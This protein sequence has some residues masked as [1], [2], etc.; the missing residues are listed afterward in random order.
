MSVSE[1]VTTTRRLAAVLAAD[2]VGYSRLMGADEEGTLARLKAHRRWLVDPKIREHRGR[3]VKTTGDGMLVEFASVV[4]AV[5]CAVEVQ[6]AMLDRE[7]DLTEDRRIQFRIGVNLGDIIVDGDDIFGDGVNVA[8]RLEALAEPGGIC[9][10]RTVRNQV[11]DKLPYG[12]EDMGEQSVKN[13]ARPVRAD[14]MSA[15]AVAATPLVAV[16]AQPV[17]ARRNIIPQRAVIAASLIVA[18]AVGLAAWWMWPHPGPSPAIVQAPAAPQSPPTAANPAP[19]VSIVV[20]PFANL[21]NDPEQEYF[22]DG[23]TDNLTTDLSRIV[24]SFVIARTTAFT[25]KGKSVDVKQIGKELGVRYVLEGSVRRLGGEVEVNAQLIDAES[26]AHIWADRFD[27]ERANL[28]KAQDDIVGRIARTLNTQIVEA[29]ARRI[30]LEKPVNPDASDYVMRG[31]AWY[32]RPNNTANLL[33]AQK[34]FERAL[35]IDPQSAEA[36]AG[37]GWVVCEFVVNGRS[38]VVDGVTISPEQDIARAEQLLLE[39]ID[40]DRDNSRARL[41]IGRLRRI[42]GNFVDAK[43]ELEKAIELDRNNATAFLQLGIA[44]IFTGQPEA[45]IPRIEHALRLIPQ[46]PNVFFFYY[47]LGHAHL[48][49]GHADEAIDILK[50]ARAAS[51]KSWGPH[52]ALAAALGLKGD[53]DEAKAALAEFLNLRPGKTYSLAKLRALP[54]NRNASPQYWALHE[55]TIDVGL[56]AAGMPEQ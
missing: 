16:Q 52:V 53:I 54:I 37:L 19:R 20:L 50:K 39:A 27:A 1:P 23:V 44:L 25:Y 18:I 56:R 35:E 32:N 31:W 34:A 8:A 11:R 22:A 2:V 46:A 42:Q 47:W 14:A 40:S 30:E 24:N 9:V 4:D 36:K 3:I 7:A 51:P 13:I 28:A 5:R 49:L 45:A 17:A 38:H 33:E 41:A 48:L 43:I 29:A 10:S 6:R 55:K 15:A 26:G 12:F 21:S